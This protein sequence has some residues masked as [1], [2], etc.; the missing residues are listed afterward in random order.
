MI[1]KPQSEPSLK[2]EEPAEDT[3]VYSYEEYVAVVWVL[4]CSV[5][6]EEFERAALLACWSNAA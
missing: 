6:Q 3:D 5:H 1:V 2:E 4:V